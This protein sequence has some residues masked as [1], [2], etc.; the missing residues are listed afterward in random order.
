MR[1]GIAKAIADATDI[2]N[3]SQFRLRQ[4][5]DHLEGVAAVEE[6]RPGNFKGR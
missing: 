4:T 5:E 2:E 3:A 6:R 1:P